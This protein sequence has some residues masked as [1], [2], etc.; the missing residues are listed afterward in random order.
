MKFTMSGVSEFFARASKKFGLD[1]YPDPK[2]PP[3]F[4]LD[5]SR[6]PSSRPPSQAF[7]LL[8]PASQ[9]Q[10]PSRKSTHLRLAFLASSLPIR[11]FSLFLDRRLRSS[12]G[13]LRFSYSSNPSPEDVVS[14]QQVAEGL[15]SSQFEVPPEPE[16]E[17]C[18][19]GFPND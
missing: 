12:G 1:R 2:E 7:L 8:P 15:F 11:V 5:G 16:Y 10:S 13:L 9:S 4:G 18:G 6:T 17:E 3:I 14:S 19:V